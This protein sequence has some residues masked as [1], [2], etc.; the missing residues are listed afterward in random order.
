MKVKP[1]LYLNMSPQTAEDGSLAFARN[2]K[3][4]DDGNLVSDY[5]YKNISAMANYNIVGHIVGLDNKIYFFCHAN[6]VS[7]IVEYDEL[8]ETATPLTTTWTYNG[9]EIDGYVNTNQSGEKILTIGEYLDN[10][11][12]IPLKHIN[13]KEQIRDGVKSWPFANVEQSLYS[14]APKCPTAN[15]VLTDTY[16]KTIPNGV[17]VFF[18]RYKL[19]KDVYTNWFLCSR[20]IF[21]GTSEEITTFQGGLKYI[22][23]HKDSAKSFVFKLDFAVN[24][25]VNLYKE[26]QLGFII[27]HDEATDARTWKHFNIDSFISGGD[28]LIYFDYDDVSETN[29]DELLETTYELYNVRNVTA[30]KNKLYISNYKE[31]DFNYNPNNLSSVIDVDSQI[32]DNEKR[33]IDKYNT[34][35]VKINN[36][37][38]TLTNYSENY[39]CYTKV[40][41]SNIR[42]IISNLSLDFDISE[43]YKGNNNEIEKCLTFNLHGLTDE[44]PDIIYVTSIDNKL[45]NNAIFGPNFSR[46]YNSS[47]NGWLDIG[48]KCVL[49]QQPLY[50]VS[51]ATNRHPLDNLGFTFAYGLFGN[52]GVNVPS[53]SYNY[54]DRNILLINKASLDA[55]KACAAAKFIDDKVRNIISEN[56]KKEIKNKSRFILGYA[57]IYD[58]TNKY[59]VVVVTGV[60]KEIFETDNYVGSDNDID[61]GINNKNNSSNTIIV[62][63]LKNKVRTI[64]STYTVG[65][66]DSGN[67]VLNIN[68]NIV[69]ANNITFNFKSCEFVVD[70]SSELDFNND[71][72]YN[73]SFNATLKTTNYSCVCS[74]NIDNSS[75]KITKPSFINDIYK[76]KST[77]LPL[78]SYDV[79]VHFVDDHNIITN[80]KFLKNITTSNSSNELYK[81]ILKYKVNNVSAINSK[82]KSFF[83]S[84]K[85]VGPIIIECF[86]Y[87]NVN[88]LHTLNVLEADTLLYNLTD[89]I[90]VIKGSNYVETVITSNAIYYPSGVSTPALA[91]GN[92]GFIA[93]SDSNTYSSDDKFY[94]KIDRVVEKGETTSLIK[95]TPYIPLRQTSNFV[96]VDDGFY[97]GYF[98][99]V[100]K[101]SITLSSAC[102]VSGTDI[103][104]ATRET[105][106]KLKNFENY[107]TVQ[108]SVIYFIRSSFNL[109]YLSLTEDINDRIYSIGSAASNLKQVAKV[110]NSA[111]LSFIYELK[112]MY[113][114]FANKVFRPITSDYKIDFDNTVRVSNV[115][116]DE[117]FNNS[118][119]KFSAEDY[120]NVPTDRGII[121]NL[122]AI[123]TNIFVHT[124]TA[125]YKFDGNQTIAAS[126]KDI[127]LQESEPFENGITQLFDSEYGYGGINNKEAGCITFDSYIFYDAMSNHIFAYGGNSQVQLIDASIYKMLCHYKPPYCRTLHDD[128]NHRVLFEF[129]TDKTSGKYK[130]F[131]ISYNYKSKSF[132]SLHDLSLVNAFHSRYISYS[133]KSGLISLFNK[134]AKINGTP[135]VQDMN[136][137]KIYGEA[138]TVCFIQFGA[139]TQDVQSS[140]FNIAVVVFPRDSYREAVNNLKYI[141]D[142]VKDNYDEK[143][144]YE[145]IKFPQITRTN[146]VSK[147]YI[148]TDR[149]VSTPVMGDVNDAQRPANPNDYKGFKYDMG[150]WNTNYFRNALNDTNVYQYPNQPGV[151]EPVAGGQTVTRHPNT[152]NNSLVYGKYFILVFDFIKNKPIKFEE[153]SVNSNQY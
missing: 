38:S 119:F 102:Y 74:Y 7:K 120:Y 2:M 42:N 17:Y 77:L 30:F 46:D 35:E 60:T 88:G 101:P 52:D 100:K 8:E 66:D 108:D 70:D 33:N 153:V 12:D 55:N 136:I 43:F 40:N 94:V 59:D 130:T 105:T 129:T 28:N 111:I 149:C 62:N 92:C 9:G 39:G 113:R 151:N 54:S 71:A 47:G 76:Q 144:N 53:A 128:E 133:Y 98:C 73:Y 78:S 58:S 99:S 69:R 25:N 89:N 118:I 124:K 145:V 80:G 109:N 50:D 114:D 20:P 93:W 6:N 110:I 95:A 29:I 96:N 147:F 5:G 44:D 116:S 23:L 36:T 57:T 132:V 3:I 83:L 72:H 1:K 141:G 22:N 107:I 13:L 137:Y 82:Y 45:Y 152:D 103:Y 68:G 122:F 131:T 14:Q 115:L 143:T 63:A 48:L 90:K 125:F 51:R 135:L 65:I 16:V 140:P 150:S 87:K 19:R 75:I 64:L 79:Y 67:I 134:I 91:F 21:G 32:I 121:V 138:T 127:T 142:I 146:P 104:A 97:G 61:Y 26:F 117:T 126:T 85:N 27:T 37:F 11:S 123:G 106:I 18:I 41:N 81:L 34:V 49:N 112:P 24:T 84:I 15:L 4:D 31:S 56:V 86:G 139:D 148:I 10:G